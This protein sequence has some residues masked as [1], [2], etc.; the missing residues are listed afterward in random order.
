MTDR[1]D[2]GPGWRLLDSCPIIMRGDEF[3]SNDGWFPSLLDPGSQ[4]IEGMV[5]RR[6]TKE[7]STK[8]IATRA[9]I[10]AECEDGIRVTR[11]VSNPSGLTTKQMEF[12]AESFARQMSRLSQGTPM[13]GSSPA[14]YIMLEIQR[15]GEP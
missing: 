14:K 5:Y 9:T 10:I 11:T 1:I 6:R 4:G 15:E 2:P 7:S 3:H 12:E 13:H 8:A